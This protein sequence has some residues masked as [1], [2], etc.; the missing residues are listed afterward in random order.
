MN[1]KNDK[2][3]SWVYFQYYFTYIILYIF[4][5]TLPNYRSNN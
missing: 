1:E 2:K 3:S 4:Y 5:H